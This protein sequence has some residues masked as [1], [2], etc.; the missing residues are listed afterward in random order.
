MNP[1]SHDLPSPASDLQE[2]ALREAGGE[3]PAPAADK[4][5]RRSTRKP[6]AVAEAAEGAAP[7]AEASSDPA[8]A[9]APAAAEEPARKTTRRRKKV[10]SEEAAQ[11]AD[12]TDAVVRTE[13]Q[14]EAGMP[15][16]SASGRTLA[17]MP[18]EGAGAVL[19]L[20]HI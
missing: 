5:K 4:P 1:D 15:G 11:S 10:A 9:A 7:R 16:E 14:A 6:K 13:P 2:E 19:S 20:I 3:A 12:S 17:G 8:E 18:D